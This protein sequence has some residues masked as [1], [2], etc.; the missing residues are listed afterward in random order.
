ISYTNQRVR[1]IVLG[2]SL[3]IWIKRV[4]LL[5]YQLYHVRSIILIPVGAGSPI[6]FAPNGQSH[7]PAPAYVLLAIDQT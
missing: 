6:I 2:Y 5:N 3:S 4:A 1:L 7:K